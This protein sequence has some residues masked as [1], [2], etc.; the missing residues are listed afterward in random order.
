MESIAETA[1]YSNPGRVAFYADVLFNC[2]APPSPESFRFEPT[3]HNEGFRRALWT[4]NNY[5]LS[6]NDETGMYEPFV[7]TRKDWEIHS[8]ERKIACVA[9]SNWQGRSSQKLLPEINH[10]LVSMYTDE[11]RKTPLL[12]AE[13]EVELA[14]QIEAGLFAC[15]KLEGGHAF[16]GKKLTSSQR[17][18]YIHLALLGKDAFD[19]FYRAN[20]PLVVSVAKRYTG[21]SMPLIDIIQEGNLGLWHAIEK[22]D[23]KKGFK[24]S[25][26]ATKW[27]NQAIIHS[28]PRQTSG[29]TLSEHVASSLKRLKT[30]WKDYELEYG[31]RPSIDSLVEKSGLSRY[32]VEMLH[33]HIQ[34]P[35]S[36]YGKNLGEDYIDKNGLRHIESDSSLENCIVADEKYSPEDILENRDI[37]SRLWRV[38]DSLEE[39]EKKA[40]IGRFGLYSDSPLSFEQLRDLLG[41][42][43]RKA[44]SQRLQRILEK[45]RLASQSN[46]LFP[47]EGL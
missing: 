23:Y 20:L 6:L 19:H 9:L 40:I 32:V 37:T 36:I 29:L 18:D 10:D 46:G 33:I 47:G 5:K 38:I 41:L 42:K 7:V 43:T 25:T 14:K 30:A 2:T 15:H 28:L 21:M 12:S 34:E 35:L 13:E 1:G 45:M 3:R 27:I 26:Y 16:Q 31:S 8:N 39:E 4:L 44:A 17:R 11:L 22:F 24:F